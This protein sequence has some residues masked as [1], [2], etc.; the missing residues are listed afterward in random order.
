MPHSQAERTRMTD[1]GLNLIQQALSIYDAD[2]K[3][4]VCNRPLRDMLDLPEYLCRPGA[5]FEETIRFL[6]DRGE[7]GEVADPDGFVRTRIEQALAFEPHYL[8]RTR[9]NGRI[10]S[11]EGCPLPQEGWVTVYTDITEI[12]RQEQLLRMRSEELSDQLLAQSEKLSKTNRELASTYVALFEV[13]RELTET[14]ARTRTVTRM[15]PAHIAHVSPEGLYTFSNRKLPTIMPGHGED[16]IGH[17]FRDVLGEEAFEKMRLTYE[18]AMAG[19][20]GVNEFSHEESGRR[21]RVAMTPD[22]APDGKPNGVYILSTDVTEEAQA[23]AALAQTHRRELAAQLTN[24]LAHD[25]ANLLTIILGLQSQLERQ[26]QSDEMID[27]IAATKAAARRGG[28]L[29]DRIAT[30]SDLRPMQ[31]EPVTLP[32]FLREI[33]TMA[34]P[35]LGERI[36]L[37]QECEGFAAPLML[38]AGSVQDSLLNLI[39]N[40]R[41]AIGKGFGTITVSAQPVGDTWVELSVSDTGPGFSAAALDHATDPFFTTKGEDG[42]GLGL[43]MVYDATKVAGGRVTLANTEE[44]A[45]VDMRFP[46]RPAELSATPG[47]VLL[48]EDSDLLREAVRE[49]LMAHGH[50]VIEAASADEAEALIDLP[51]LSMVLS[52]MILVGDRSG[53]DLLNGLRAKGV[54]AKM[55]LMTSL[56]ASDPR[57]IEAENTFPLIS[58]PFSTLK[59]DEALRKG[60]SA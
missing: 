31:L 33:C 58:K 11:I 60:P 47:L 48:V 30:M 52:D 46:L 4:V 44:G 8:E 42:S 25:F 32:G 10:I 34:R 40:A 9:P 22:I 38:D 6:V 49:E 57:R 29:L 36:L 27:L 45:R 50:T 35:S 37:E 54:T 26:A 39:L 17:S 19:T 24:G 18:A 2:L 15:M 41:D 28:T 53:L 7:Y 55:C 1:A 13:K 5:S 43:T 12:R 16:I 21:L 23:R 56:P 59:L 3:L 14:E 51:G 20:P